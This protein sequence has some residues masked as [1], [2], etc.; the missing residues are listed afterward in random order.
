MKKMDYVD[1]F[2]LPIPRKNIARYKRSARLFAKV[3]R[4]HGAVDYREF[5]GDD[6]H[7]PGMVPFT[8]NVKV[9]KGEVLVGAYV[10]YPSRTVRDR[11]NRKMMTDPRMEKAMKD[12]MKNPPFDMKRMLYGG[13]KT[14]VVM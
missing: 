1:L 6:L 10:R 2:L 7:S 8:K 5:A 13:F 3:I 4:S 12:M 14:I 11:A 9:K